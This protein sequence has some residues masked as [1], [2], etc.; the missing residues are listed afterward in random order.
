MLQFL[1]LIA[2][3]GA[4]VGRVVLPLLT[5]A[6]PTIATAAP[7]VARTAPQVAN[8]APQVVRAA[9]QAKMASDAMM[10]QAQRASNLSLGA[11]RT[12]QT[13]QRV[14]QAVSVAKTP[15]TASKA[16]GLAKRPGVPAPTRQPCAATQRIKAENLAAK[17]KAVLNKLAQRASRKAQ[18]KAAAL[19]RAKA[20][21]LKS[22]D[23]PKTN[24]GMR[25]D[26]AA[27]DA[28]H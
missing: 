9:P 28:L 12:A 21:T 3:G 6:A 18:E 19:E 26:E 11:T 13:G 2:A 24:V 20:A 25:V 1:P 17:R 15:G 10:L 23:I 16:S 27:G 4:A 22:R 7:T 14:Q 5:R 8:A